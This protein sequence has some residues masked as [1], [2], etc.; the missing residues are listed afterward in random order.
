MEP[1]PDGE[2]SYIG[3]GRLRGR[4][5]LITGGDLGIGRAV[6]IAYSR[7]CADVAFTHMAEESADAEETA[8]L[9]EDANVRVVPTSVDLQSRTACD[10]VIPTVIEGL[11]GLDLLVNN[12]GYQWARSEGLAELSDE[13]L[14]QTMTKT[15]SCCSG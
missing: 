15:C 11:G 2:S 10:D 14:E 3:R 12:A 1:A 8:R 5:S 9:I 13:H 7:E 6:A 4:G